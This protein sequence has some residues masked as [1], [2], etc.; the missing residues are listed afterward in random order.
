MIEQA[1]VN[2]SSAPLGQTST[3]AKVGGYLLIALGILGLIMGALKL[4]TD[5]AHLY[6]DL[7]FAIVDTVTALMIIG[8][9]WL[10]ITAKSPAK[11]IT[12]LILAAIAGIFSLSGFAA[13]GWGSAT[14]IIGILYLIS[15]APL[16][17][18]YGR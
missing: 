2:T 6:P 8:A 12:P 18:S 3:K 9:G 10:G 11:V 5:F 17:I 13:Y 1:G 16:A 7:V 14:G 4:A 15:A